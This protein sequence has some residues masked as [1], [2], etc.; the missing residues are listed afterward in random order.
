MSSVFYRYNYNLSFVDDTTKQV[1]K[2]TI[3]DGDKGL[4][5]KYISINGKEFYKF[6]ALEIKNGTFAIKEKINTVET[7][8]TLSYTELLNIINTTDILKFV[9]D[10]INKKSTGLSTK[11][12]SIKPTNNNSDKPS[13]IKSD[14]IVDKPSKSKSDTPIKSKSKKV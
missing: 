2:H 3:I 1:T 11:S 6:E 9:L 13:K 5:F 7:T 10:Y 14:K 8:K 4:S 12:K